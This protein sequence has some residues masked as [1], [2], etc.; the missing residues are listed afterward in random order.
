MWERAVRYIEE[1]MRMN[2][3]RWLKKFLKEEIRGII[4]GDATI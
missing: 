2:D 3:S 4:N 1:V